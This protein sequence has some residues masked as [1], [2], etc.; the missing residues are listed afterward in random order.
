MS[1]IIN[2]TW[3]IT[4]EARMSLLYVVGTHRMWGVYIYNIHTFI[5]HLLI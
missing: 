2:G 3:C 5:F 4:W 1:W